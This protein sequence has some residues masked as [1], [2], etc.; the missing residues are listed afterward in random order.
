[1]SQN[2][3]LCPASLAISQP[4]SPLTVNGLNGVS[5]LIFVYC[6]LGAQIILRPTI[7]SRLAR[8]IRVQAG[9]VTRRPRIAQIV[10]RGPFV[11]AIQILPCRNR[12]TGS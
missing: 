6:P 7:L 2:R 8:G 11:G 3:S 9:P 12:W 1:M 10:R 5:Y 4:T